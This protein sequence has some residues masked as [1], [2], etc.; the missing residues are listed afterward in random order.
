MEAARG[1]A[2]CLFCCPGR[3]VPGPVFP[4]GEAGGPRLALERPCPRVTAAV[5]SL[6]SAAGGCS[7]HLPLTPQGFVPLP[8]AVGGAEGHD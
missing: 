2:F 3:S 5:A 7:P 8:R 6:P 1:R 4:E